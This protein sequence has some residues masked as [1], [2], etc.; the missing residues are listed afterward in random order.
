MGLSSWLELTALVDSG[1]AE[2]VASA[3]GRF[4]H[5]GAAIEE[6]RGGGPPSQAGK[7]RVR[8]FIPVDDLLPGRRAE[9]ERA[10]SQ[11]RLRCPVELSPRTVDDQE[12]ETIWRAHFPVLAVGRRLVVK[13]SWEEHRARRGQVVLE[14]DPGMAFGTG[15]HATTRLCLVALERHL[16]PG[17]AVLDV[18][19]GSGI[20]AIAAAKLGASAVAALDINPVAVDVARSN[21]ASNG[22]AGVVSVE[23]GG[24]PFERPLGPFDIVMANILSTVVCELAP[25]LAGALRPGGVLVASGFIDVHCPEVSER[26]RQEGLAVVETMAEGDWRAL[27]AVREE[28]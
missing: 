5:G 16:A 17:M 1:D 22:V 10:L 8:A 7:A 4:G 21:I 25:H 6:E 28:G 14:I 18:G 24:L 3:M 11:L 26:L 27:V 13:P 12:W 9:M 19:T 2:V 23:L 15:H 20:L